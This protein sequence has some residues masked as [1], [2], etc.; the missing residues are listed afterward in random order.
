[1]A[2][3]LSRLIEDEL[4][5]KGFYEGGAAKAPAKPIRVEPEEEDAEVG[6]HQALMGALRVEVRDG[7][8]PS[9]QRKRSLPQ[10]LNVVACSPAQARVK[11]QQAARHTATIKRS[12]CIGGG[13]LAVIVL[14][15][16]IVTSS[17]GGAHR[18]AGQGV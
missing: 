18:A 3:E 7:S 5:R 10:S 12:I 13:L 17:R 16:I 2:S 15:V 8:R 6:S 11:E 14:V 4:S 1:M 9:P